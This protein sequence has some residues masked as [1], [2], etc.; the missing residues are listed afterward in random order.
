MKLDEEYLKKE[1][2]EWRKLIEEL[3]KIVETKYI[4]TSITNFKNKTNFREPKFVKG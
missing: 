4:K 1:S 2:I 3:E